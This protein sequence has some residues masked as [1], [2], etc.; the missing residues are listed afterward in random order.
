MKDA[1]GIGGVRSS[2]FAWS[3]S[4]DEEKGRAGAQIDLVIDRDDRIVNLCEIKYTTDP[5]EIDKEEWW[6]LDAKI[7]R[8]VEGAKKKKTV[9]LTILSA[10]GVAKTGYASRVNKVL[11]LDALF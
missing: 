5:F 6:K 10:E 8:Y 9:F 1:L 3:V 11:T 7:G 4:P 2:V